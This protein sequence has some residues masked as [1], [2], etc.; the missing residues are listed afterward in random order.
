M[1][2]A[3]RLWRESK[4]P[5]GV[6][7]DPATLEVLRKNVAFMTVRSVRRLQRR[8]RRGGQ[9]HGDPHARLA[10]RKLRESKELGGEELD[11]ATLAFLKTNVA[12]ITAEAFKVWR[13]AATSR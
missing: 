5:N 4:D 1:S 7:L 10:F 2:E 3:F 8:H 6:P 9:P 13:I 11:P 12:F